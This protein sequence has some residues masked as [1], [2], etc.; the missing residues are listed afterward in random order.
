MWNYKTL[1]ND[2]KQ[3][4]MPKE[5]NSFSDIENFL[6]NYLL[7]AMKITPNVKLK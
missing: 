2:R 1:I 7:L 5:I 6:S 4:I 3:I